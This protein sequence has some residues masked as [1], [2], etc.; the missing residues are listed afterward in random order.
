[1]VWKYFPS[2]LKNL[3]IWCQTNLLVEGFRSITHCST[4]VNLHIRFVDVLKIERVV[5]TKH[6]QVIDAAEE[7]SSARQMIICFRVYLRRVQQDM[8]DAGA[9]LDIQHDALFQQS[10]RTKKS[11]QIEE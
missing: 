4:K 11:T 3:D 8:A 5:V 6:D 9:G 1:M 7:V 2:K 10:M